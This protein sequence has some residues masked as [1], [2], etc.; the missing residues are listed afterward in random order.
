MN[1]LHFGPLAHVAPANAI[2]QREWEALARV[3][4]E[5]EA[6]SKVAHAHVSA[7]TSRDD[8]TSSRLSDVHRSLNEVEAR[9]EGTVRDALTRGG[10]VPYEWFI[11]LHP[12]VTHE[13]L[14]KL[15]GGFTY[16]DDENRAR[17]G[18][19]EVD[20]DVQL[21]LYPPVSSA[22][23]NAGNRNEAPIAPTLSEQHGPAKS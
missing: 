11:Q 17:V 8:Q 7:G 21:R 23:M 5:L 15:Y 2:T 18:W 14:S 19:P 3:L 16:E 4:G 22:K 20:W 1:R 6:S 13:M 10:L 12:R 9:L